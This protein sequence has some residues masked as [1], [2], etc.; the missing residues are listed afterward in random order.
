MGIK[1][2]GEIGIV[3]V[4]APSPTRCTTPPAAASVHCRSRRDTRR[5][6]AKP[7]ALCHHGTLQPTAP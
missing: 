5:L 6:L 1:G 2:L 7:E 4:S 3:G